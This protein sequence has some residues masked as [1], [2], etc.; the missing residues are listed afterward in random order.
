MQDRSGH[1]GVPHVDTK[2]PTVPAPFALKTDQRAAEHHPTSAGDG[3]VF[4]F[5]AQGDG[6]R[7]TR[8]KAARK[9][10]AAGA[11]SMWTGQLTQPEPFRLATD[12]RG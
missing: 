7:V 1:L 4:V 12:A 6:G 8:S 10:T 3:D 9:A 11:G 2:P 5:G